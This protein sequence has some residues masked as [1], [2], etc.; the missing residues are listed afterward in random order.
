MNWTIPAI[1]RP[2]WPKVP[3]KFLFH[4]TVLCVILHSFHSLTLSHPA[5]LLRLHSI[6]GLG[7]QVSSN[8]YLHIKH[9]FYLT[10]DPK[11]IPTKYN[12]TVILL[13]MLRTESGH[14]GYVICFPWS[15]K[16][17]HFW[18]W[19]ILYQKA[20]WPLTRHWMYVK[21]I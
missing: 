18:K 10:N 4:I 14:Y 8:L 19:S 15:V 13:F 2:N 9:L 17:R 16:Y 7:W 21:L 5:P 6:H 20:L 1:N 12:Q 11:I 3:S